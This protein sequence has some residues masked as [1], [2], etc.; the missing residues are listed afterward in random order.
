MHLF[1]KNPEPLTLL[2][3]PIPL[4][5]DAVHKIIYFYLFTCGQSINWHSHY[6]I[7]WFK[8]NTGN[9]NCFSFT[10]WLY[11]LR[12]FHFWKP[13]KTT[14]FTGTICLRFCIYSNSFACSQFKILQ[15]V[16]PRSQKVIKTSFEGYCN[17]VSIPCTIV[18]RNALFV[19]PPNWKNN[20]IT[21]NISAA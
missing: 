10:Q 20:A 7:F 4:F 5:N 8:T 15:G 11:K 14:V 6:K 18:Q 12:W 1:L 16:K 13:I 2:S 17:N 3:F 21:A 9:K 19:R